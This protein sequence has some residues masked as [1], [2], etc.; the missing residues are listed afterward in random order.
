M[1]PWAL[2]SQRGTEEPHAALL[3]KFEKKQTK[4]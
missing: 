2:R 1:G 4:N 3:S